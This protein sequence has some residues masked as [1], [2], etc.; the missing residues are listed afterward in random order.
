MTLR[1]IG[2]ETAGSESAKTALN[3]GTS[4]ASNE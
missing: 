4:G 1:V 3:T 2:E